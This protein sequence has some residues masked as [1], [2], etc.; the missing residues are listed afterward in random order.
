[1]APNEKTLSVVKFAAPAL[2][3]TGHMP[4]SFV[5]FCWARKLSVIRWTAS[6]YFG[7]FVS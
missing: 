4:G 3:V 2:T 7:S 5:L 6:K 1:M